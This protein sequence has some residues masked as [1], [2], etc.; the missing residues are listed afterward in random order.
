MHVYHHIYHFFRMFFSILI[1]H[2]NIFY[3]KNSFKKWSEF[4]RLQV[5]YWYIT[6]VH[7]DIF[8]GTNQGGHSFVWPATKDAI[9]FILSH[10]EYLIYL[11]FNFLIKFQLRNTIIGSW[12]LFGWSLYNA[13]KCRGSYIN[14]ET[15]MHSYFFFNSLMSI[16]R[17]ID[18]PLRTKGGHSIKGIHFPCLIWSWCY[19]YFLCFVEAT[20]IGIWWFSLWMTHPIISFWVRLP[21]SSLL[22]PSLE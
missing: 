8:L 22:I 7:F 20:Y 18:L 5:I 2:S 6:C 3:N 21:L 11:V 9:N 15:I 16:K 10:L 1:R 14:M 12:F 17:V 19:S 4:C 13:W